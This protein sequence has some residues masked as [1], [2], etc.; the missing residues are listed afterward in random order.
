MNINLKKTKVMILQKH[1]SKLQTFDFLLGDKR[2]DITNE[3]T[4]LGLK[5]TPPAQI[6][7]LLFIHKYYK[8]NNIV[9]SREK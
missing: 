4:Y 1:N 2:I 6:R 5:L 9:W 7:P 3:Y 8:K